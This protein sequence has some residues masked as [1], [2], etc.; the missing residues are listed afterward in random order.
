MQVP[1]CFWG[2]AVKVA[3]YLLN[4]APTK[5]LNGKTPYEAWYGRRPGVRHLRTFGC[6]AYAKKI[7]I[8]MNKL[9]D[10]SI[11]GVFLGY[12]SGTKAYRVFDPVNNKLIV[13]RDVIFDEKKS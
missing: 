5:S 8:G 11:P 10:R 4:R 6:V 2:E 3:V 7:G 1:G 9:S 12:E 13:S